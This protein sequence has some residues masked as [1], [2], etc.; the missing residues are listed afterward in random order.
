MNS[1]AQII[2]AFVFRRIGEKRIKE[3][4]FY[5]YISIDLNWLTPLDAKEFIK[6]AKREKLLSSDGEYITPLFNIENIDVPFGFRPSKNTYQEN[7]KTIENNLTVIINKLSKSLKIDKNEIMN[8]IIEIA[9][10]KNII[11]EIAGLL[12]AK[13]YEV[14][15]SKNYI[16]IEKDIFK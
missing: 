13:Q 5:L 4:D 16:K 12:L 9:E 10:E 2:I 15:L 7:N 11:I 1:D 14:D 6:R 8:K 3:S